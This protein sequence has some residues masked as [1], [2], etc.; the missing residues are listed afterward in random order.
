MI[1]IKIG[2]RS[3]MRCLCVWGKCGWDCKDDLVCSIN[4]GYVQIGRAL[5]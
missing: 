4:L 1:G 3:T 2:M 5:I